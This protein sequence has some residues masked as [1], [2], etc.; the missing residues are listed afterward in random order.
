MKTKTNRKII[1]AAILFA[2][3]ILALILCY[4]KFV[5]GTSAGGKTIS[6]EVIHGDGNK[7]DFTYQTDAEY[8]GDVLVG[9]GLAEGSESEYGLYIETVDGEYADYDADGA[10]WA[11]YVN[12]EYGMYGADAQPVEDGDSFTLEYTV[13]VAE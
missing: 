7:S 12:G 2:V 9:E 3:L 8:L 5:P 11:I 1:V 6:V 10:Y 13:Y 4:K